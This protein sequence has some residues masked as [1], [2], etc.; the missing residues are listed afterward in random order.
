MNTWRCSNLLRTYFWELRC[1][2]FMTDAS[3]NRKVTV[4]LFE[5]FELYCNS[6]IA[7]KSTVCLQELDL[8][9]FSGYIQMIQ[10]VLSKS[11]NQNTLDG[12]PIYLSVLICSQQ[13][14]NC[15]QTLAISC[16]LRMCTLMT[17][18]VTVTPHWAACGRVGYE[19]LCPNHGSQMVPR[20]PKGW[21]MDV[22]DMDL[23][24]EI[25]IEY[26]CCI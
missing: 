7:N 12:C 20:H 3:L 5:S 24:L 9:I 13:I 26:N 8:L 4:G 11:W 22:S 17:A 21:N 16:H 18:A 19:R 10:Y 14:T 15:S 23:L 25:T 1:A 6:R 2:K